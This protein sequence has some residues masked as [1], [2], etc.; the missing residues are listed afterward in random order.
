[1]PVC[2]EIY[3]KAK[4]KE[5][6]GVINRKFG[7]IKYQK[8]YASHLYSL[9]KYWFCHENRKKNYPQVYL[10]EWKYKIKKKKMPEFMDIELEPDS[11]SG[12][13]WL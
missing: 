4:V 1:M 12:S 6:N 10:E 11:R 2:N 13:E 5:F 8:R 3:I 9:Y 7:V